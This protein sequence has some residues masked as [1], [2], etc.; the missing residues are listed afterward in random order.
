MGELAAWFGLGA[1]NNIL[2]GIFGQQQQKS[3]NQMNLAMM[4]E[5]NQFNAL[6]AEKQRSFA[7]DQMAAQMAFMSPQ[8]QR[9]MYEDAGF[10]PLAALGNMG[11]PSGSAGVAASS[12]ASHPQQPVTAFSDSVRSALGQSAQIAEMLANA[13][14][15]N[16]E[17]DQLHLQNQTFLEKFGL[18]MDAL[19]LGNEFQRFRNEYESKTLPEQ[20]LNTKLTNDNITSIIGLNEE[21]TKLVKINRVLRE[22]FGYQKEVGEIQEML[23]RIEKT[24]SESELNAVL[25]EYYP[26]AAAAQLTSA[27]AQLKTAQTGAY[28]A[29]HQAHMFDM[30][31]LNQ[32]EQSELQDIL[33]RRNVNENDVYEFLMANGLKGNLLIQLENSSKMSY[34][35][36]RS[37]EKQIAEQNKKL[38]WY[39]IRAIMDIASLGIITK[40]IPQSKSAPSSSGPGWYPTPNGNSYFQY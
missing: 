22:T 4:R 17:S 35:Q 39:D 29:P 12:A 10:N 36:L 19:G 14:K 8:N 1:M 24:K 25:K 20:I 34:E 37:I 27:A 26:K 40:L 11:S 15:N 28:L 16:A 38:S 2:G 13:K 6:E 33:G 32:R 23:A 18:E 7:A 9:K 30:T 3:A 21:Q 31:A 5:Q